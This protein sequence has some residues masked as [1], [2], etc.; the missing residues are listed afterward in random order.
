[1]KILVINAGSSSLKY[2][3][4]DMQTEKAI[5]KGVCEKIGLADDASFITHNG[6]KIEK[7]MRNHSDALKYVLECLTDK[8]IGV[9]SDVSEIGAV[10]H[11]VLHG[12]EVFSASAYVD[13]D[14]LKKVDDLTPLGP[15]HMPANVGCIRQ[16]REIMPNVPMV[17]VFDTVFHA[18]MPKKAYLYAVPLADY[19]NYKIRK[20]GFH[21]T[22][23]KYVTGEALKYLNKPDAKIIVCHLGNGSSLS[24]TIGG[25]CMDTSMGY[26]PLEGLMMGSRSGD[27]DPAAVVA[28][29][30]KHN[31]TYDQ[32][33][34][35]LNKK[36]GLLG[37]A[38]Q[39]DMRTLDQ[40]IEKGDQ[41]AALAVEMFEYRVKKYIG[42]FAAALGGVDAICFTGG[43]GENSASS[44]KN[45]VKG[46]EFMGVKLDE[47]ANNCRGKFADI[48]AADSKVKL[49]VIPT[50]EELVIARD[51]LEIVS[52]L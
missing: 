46:L 9:I 34:N 10:G 43:I 42:S 13:E 25:K 51:T 30:K 2:Q 18:T 12:G 36:S 17:G 39:S 52:K 16:C 38:G 14:F 22:S 7:D 29:G 8:E 33:D 48:T 19:E 15:L 49:L 40:M 47:A 23:H 45:I 32:L 44:R 20:Y 11:R 21:G 27:M 50:N 28:I 1:M 3:L 41:N 6:Q 35:Y 31:F 4:I 5:A 37:I 26:T 24:A